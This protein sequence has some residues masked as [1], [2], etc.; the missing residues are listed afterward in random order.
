MK[1]SKFLY[2]TKRSTFDQLV[3]DFPAWLSPICF[4]EDT[5][6]IWF[7]NHFFQAGNERVRISEMNGAVTVS[8]SDSGFNLVPGSSSIGITS[9]E[10]NIV[11]SCNALTRIDTDNWLEWKNDRLYH[12]DSGVTQGTYGQNADASGANSITVPKITV[13]SK[14]HSTKI[15]NKTVTIRD[16][17]EQRKSDNS[18]SDRPVL[19]AERDTDF[20]DT[21][22]TRK[23]KNITY[24][25]M[26]QTL[27]VP[28]V[29]VSGTKQRSFVIKNGDLVVEEGMIIGNIQGNVTGTATPKIHLSEN[30]DY[31]GASK[32]LYGHVKLVD[33]MPANPEPSSD[34]QDPNNQEVKATAASPYLVYNYVQASKIKVNAINAAKQ[35][36]DISDQFDFTDDF[37]VQ[38]SKISI[39]WIEL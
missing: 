16:Y 17:V 2:F 21:N 35:K 36:V 29:E 10:N 39:N 9:N 28:N 12:K 11:I 6:E 32:K 7:N 18:N 3:S 22:T 33:Q 30:P 23:G 5:N 25:N 31:G 8:L 37:V 14:G 34:N 24:N 4:I 26:N 19:I 38:N 27:K 13:D 15:E 20:D 1:N